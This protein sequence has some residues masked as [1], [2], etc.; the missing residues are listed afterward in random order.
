MP[1]QIIDGDFPRS[2]SVVIDNNLPNDDE[3]ESYKMYAI[4]IAG[5]SIIIHFRWKA[6]WL[7]YFDLLILFD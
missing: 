3:A 4:I 6:L 1:W 2:Q 7:I 5:E